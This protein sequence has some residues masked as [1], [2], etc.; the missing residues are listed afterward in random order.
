MRSHPFPIHPSVSNKTVDYLFS[1]GGRFPA[2]SGKKKR[3][4]HPQGRHVPPFAA[5]AS[6]CAASGRGQGRATCFCSSMMGRAGGEDGAKG[7]GAVEPKGGARFCAAVQTASCRSIRGALNRR[8]AA[9]GRR[10]GSRM[11]R[12]PLEMP[13][14][15]PRAAPAHG[16]FP[17]GLSARKNEGLFALHWIPPDA[18]VCWT[19]CCIG[20]ASEKISRWCCWDPGIRPRWRH[21]P[22]ER[23]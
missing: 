15:V 20:A 8:G 18:A 6:P 17:G 22:P 19:A 1:I 14:L 3:R 4:K 5:P 21:P 23:G 13:T 12:R 16:S 11:A 10:A 2:F 9:E 7:R